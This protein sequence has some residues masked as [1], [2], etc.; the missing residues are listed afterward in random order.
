MKSDSEKLV[1]LIVV[2][3]SGVGKSSLL[4]RYTHNEYN[5][6]FLAT[7]GM[8]FYVR[9]IILDEEK[10]KLHIFDSSG[11]E[12]FRSIIS[13]YY[14]NGHGIILMY[15]TTNLKSFQNLLDWNKSVEKYSLKDPVRVLVG[16]KTDLK[17]NRQVT[18]AMAKAFADILKID[19]FEVSSKLNENI[20][21]MFDEFIRKV[22]MNEKNQKEMN[23]IKLVDVK[24]KTSKCCR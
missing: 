20:N 2:G 15:D 17:E 1:K 10:Y 21:E 6:H 9:R 5:D 13:S 19:H 16:T 8:D 23:S 7:I 14:R 4:V 3:D 24:G 12:R 18:E 22:S 11:Q